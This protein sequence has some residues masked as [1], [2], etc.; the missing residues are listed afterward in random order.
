MIV[1]QIRTMDET[2]AGTKAQ[3]WMQSVI[4]RLLPPIVIDERTPENL[5][6]PPY[7]RITSVQTPCNG[8]ESGTKITTLWD[9][10]RPRAMYILQR[11]SANFTV[12][13]MIEVQT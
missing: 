7:W 13:T 2:D 5:L 1:T 12:A 8:P 11:D 4:N 10:S 3:D 6:G 9:Q